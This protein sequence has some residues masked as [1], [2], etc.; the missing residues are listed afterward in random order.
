[1]DMEEEAT[2]EEVGV[3]LKV[4]RWRRGGGTGLRCLQGGGG[5]GGGSHEFRGRRE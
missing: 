4:I 1:M 5:G 3:D 2:R